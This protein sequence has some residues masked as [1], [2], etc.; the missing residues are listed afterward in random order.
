MSEAREIRKA[1]YDQLL[2]TIEWRTF[3]YRTKALANF[4]CA[5]CRQ[6]GSGIELNV[7]HHAYDGTRLPWEYETH[8]VAVLC[9][10]CHGQM[11]G[12]L[13]EFRKHVFRLLTPQTFNVLNGALAVGLTQYEPLTFCH[14]LANLAGS[15]GSVQR[16][17]ESYV[18]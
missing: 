1:R 13:Q 11:H 6:G 16:F 14:A 10:P 3:A 18:R 7:H 12:A 2:S 5:I 8:E 15:P 4:S 17:A 9:K